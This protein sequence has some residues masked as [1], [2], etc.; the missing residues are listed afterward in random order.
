MQSQGT[1]NDDSA[2]LLKAQVVPFLDD[3]LTANHIQDVIPSTDFQALSISK[4]LQDPPGGYHHWILNLPADVDFTRLEQAC[5]D[6]ANHFDIFRSV[7]VPAATKDDGKFWRVILREHTPAYD[8]ID[9]GDSK[10][11]PQFFNAVC[12]ED[13]AGPRR[14]GQFFIR[15]IAINI[16]PPPLALTSS[17][18]AFPTLTS[19]ALAGRNFSMLSRLSTSTSSRSQLS[20]FHQPPPPSPHHFPPFFYL[21]KRWR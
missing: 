14:L 3:G 15:F 12:A 6:L 1:E 2:D 7:F 19:T 16:C 20:Q 4:N 17:S 11:L 8:T 9:A 5:R 18:S 13:L 21:V 10:D